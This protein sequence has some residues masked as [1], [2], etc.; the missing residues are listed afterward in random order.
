MFNVASRVGGATARAVTNATIARFGRHRRWPPTELMIAEPVSLAE[1][2]TDRLRRLYGKAAATAWDADVVFRE[3]MG[4]HGGIQLDADRRR[5]LVHPLTMLMWGELAAWN[6]AAE[7]A[8]QIEEPDARMAASAQVFDEA[9]HFY[10]LRDYVAALHVPVPALD[11]Y[12]AI[13]VRRLM[14][15]DDLT[16]KLF[17]MQILAEGTATVAFRFLAD[18]AL[19]PV[20]SELLMLIERDEV[21]HVGFGVLYLPQRLARMQPAELRRVRNTIM[22][23]GDLFGLAQVRIAPHY[24]RLGIEPRELVRRADR[25]LTDIGQKMGTIPGSDEPYFRFDDPDTPGYERKLEL[26]FPTDEEKRGFAPRFI[27]NLIDAGAHILP[28]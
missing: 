18:H 6:V 19:E 12:F 13:A 27:A 26:L 22:G 25:M 2:R 15:C 1:E 21:R 20:L 8:D 4:K 23:V 10:A 5:A 9:R 11:P 14:G 24:R 17:A 28:S 3:L 7:L 16:V